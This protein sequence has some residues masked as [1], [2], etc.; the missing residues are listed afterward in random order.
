MVKHVVL[1]KLDARYSDKEKEI[2]RSEFRQKLLRLKDQITVLLNIEVY[3]K[4]E[5]ASESNFDIM[6]DTV[7]NSLDDLNTYQL[8]PSHIKVVEYVK[9]LKLQRAAIDFQF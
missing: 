5:Q 7:F 8:H 4:S 9:S 6:L 3:L 2:I 1:W